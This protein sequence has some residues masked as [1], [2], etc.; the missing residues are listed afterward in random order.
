MINYTLKYGVSE[1][2]RIFEVDRNTIKSWAYHFSDYLNSEANPE[3]GITRQFCIEDIRVLAYVFLYWED[4]PDFENIRH[5]LNSNNHWNNELINNKIKSVIPIFRDILENIDE[6]SRGIVFGGEFKLSTL[7]ETANSFKLAGDNLVT[8]A[9]DNYEERNL[10][11]PAIYNY[12]HAT[13][14]YIK[15]I[16]GSEIT[17]NLNDLKQKLSKTLKENFNASIPIWFSNIIDAFHYADPSGSTFR[18][19]ESLPYQEM[20]VDLNHVKTLMNWMAES[21]EIIRREIECR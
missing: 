21:F 8:I 15:A 2:A 17:H 5:G 7:F 20:Y 11:L 9:H 4:E 1:V 14:L 10:F 12:R 13:E 3:K 6:S 19:A 16:S 18:Y